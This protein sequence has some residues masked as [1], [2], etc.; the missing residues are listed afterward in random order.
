MNLYKSISSPVHTY[1]KPGAPKTTCGSMEALRADSF[2]TGLSLHSTLR[3]APNR[4]GQAVASTP[5]DSATRATLL[6]A[7]SILLRRI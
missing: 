4:S 6:R 5:F 2:S 3:L 7:G 1:F